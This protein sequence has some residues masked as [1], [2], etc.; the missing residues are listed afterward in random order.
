MTPRPQTTPT[1]V[2][3]T[4]HNTSGHR[5]P[6][7]VATHRQKVLIFLNRKAL[8]TPLIEMSVSDLV[9]NASIKVFPFPFLPKRRRLLGTSGSRSLLL[10]CHRSILAKLFHDS[11]GNVMR[12]VECQQ[13]GVILR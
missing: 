4:I 12:L 9:A 1:P 8:E 3:R 2:L 13:N 10:V 6:L 11:T 5:V 7:D